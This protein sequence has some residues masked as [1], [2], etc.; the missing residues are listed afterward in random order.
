QVGLGD[1]RA[2]IGAQIS[3]H[4]LPYGA[5]IGK[6]ESHA[7]DRGG[8]NKRGKYQTGQRE[9]LDAPRA[10]LAKRVGVR[11]QLAIGEDLQVEAAISLLFDR[12]RHFARASVHRVRFWK[13][14]CVFV[15][16][17]RLLSASDA[18]GGGGAKSVKLAP[19]SNRRRVIA[20]FNLIAGP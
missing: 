6:R 1:L 15:D 2:D 9:E 16:P 3:V 17:L 11:T 20:G 13:I 14:V 7:V 19:A 8:W 5:V 4:R 12:G 18:R 10:N